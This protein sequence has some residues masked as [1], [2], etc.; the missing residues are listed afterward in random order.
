MNPDWLSRWPS[1]MAPRPLPALARNS[2]RE[3]TGTDVGLLVGHSVRYP[4]GRVLGATRCAPYFS[5]DKHKC[6]SSPN[7]YRNTNS[8]EFRIE[9]Q[10]ST[11]AAASAGLMFSAITA[12]EA[13]FSPF[14]SRSVRILV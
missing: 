6:L 3:R 10:K 2:R 12:G 1:A 8:F 13:S 7:Q 14:A 5:Q 4:Y 9:W 11:S